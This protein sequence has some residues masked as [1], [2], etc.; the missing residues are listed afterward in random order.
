MSD[1]R[2][3]DSAAPIHQVKEVQFSILSPEEIVRTLP[4]IQAPSRLSICFVEL[5]TLAISSENVLG[6]DGQ[7]FPRKAGL[8][9]HSQFPFRHLLAF[10]NMVLRP[11]VYVDFYI[12][13]VSTPAFFGARDGFTSGRPRSHGS[14]SKMKERQ[15]TLYEKR[16]RQQAEKRH[17]RASVQAVQ[18]DATHQ[19][20]RD[21][22][23]TPPRVDRTAPLFTEE[24]LNAVQR[25]K[26]SKEFFKSRAPQAY[27][28]ER[29]PDGSTN[30]S[31]VLQ[32]GSDMS[33][34]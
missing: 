18:R 11:L 16:V 34:Q 23:A 20:Y 30:W 29:L 13:F 31:G 4:V 1:H 28:G 9:I 26:I 6:F 24:A 7:G 27:L 22:L 3:A 5:G 33:N 10:F 21:A 14:I 8:N 19:R 2:F 15:Q 12:V 32:R 25:E 17:E